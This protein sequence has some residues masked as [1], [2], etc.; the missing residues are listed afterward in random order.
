MTNNGILWLSDI[1]SRIA[2]VIPV[3]V[4]LALILILRF[5]PAVP[6]WE[7]YTSFKSIPYIVA[8]ISLLL[9]IFF[10]QSKIAFLSVL[11]AAITYLLKHA[12]GNAES[13]NQA[14]ALIF[15][16]SIYIPPMMALFYHLTERGILTVHGYIRLIIIFSAIIVILLLP[17]IES[18]SNLLSSK[19][20]PFIFRPVGDWLVLPRIGVIL[21]L[22]TV[23]FFFFRNRHETP[24]TGALLLISMFGALMGLNY[25]SSFWHGRG[26]VVM[27]TFMIFS[28]S[29]LTWAVLESIWRH[30]H[31]D[32]LTELPARRAMRHHFASLGSDYAISVV[33]VDHFKRINDH[34]GHSTGDQVLRYIA[35]FLKAAQFGKAYRYG[36][37]E[38]VII[39]EKPDFKMLVQELENLRKTIHKRPFVVRGKDRPKKKEDMQVKVGDDAGREKIEIAVSIGVARSSDTLTNPTDVMNAADDALYRAKEAG[40]NQLKIGK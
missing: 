19:D 1:K 39:S 8:M 37:E 33:D 27:N 17:S 16:S 22:V 26:H 11:L 38:F 31:M 3:V 6:T 24:F 14:H 20:L 32:E 12:E 40:R 21:T 2:V 18:I 25:M 23:P 7:N 10:H 4:F 9:G 30:A 13:S 29:V 28:L 5:H 35:S 15:L 36:G 34:Y